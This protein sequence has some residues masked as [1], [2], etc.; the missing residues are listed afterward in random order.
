MNSFS[1]FRAY[2]ALV[3]VALLS[4]ALPACNDEATDHRPGSGIE[5]CVTEVMGPDRIEVYRC[6]RWARNGDDTWSCDCDG[7]VIAHV[8]AQQSCE[9]AVTAHC[10][11]PAHRISCD[12]EQLGECQVRDGEQRCRCLGGEAR[13][14][15]PEATCSPALFE[16]CEGEFGG[17][18]FSCSDALRGSCAWNE[19]QARFQCDCLGEFVGGDPDEGE[20]ELTLEC[21]LALVLTC[22][23]RICYSHNGRCGRPGDD[24][25]DDWFCEC[26]DGTTSM[27]TSAELSDPDDCE[28]APHIACP[29]STDGEPDSACFYTHEDRTRS[30]C[31]I[32]NHAYRCECLSDGSIGVR[33]GTLESQ[34]PCELLMYDVCN[35]ERD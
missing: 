3:L 6:E 7:D 11:I 20:A 15:D 25:D 9:A 22:D 14:V 23:S 2:A 30:S 19:E 18:E 33:A 17:A 5:S 24:N 32:W 10:E 35:I 29:D 26:D 28:D 34:W 1:R 16:N 4:P 13:D 27:V 21:G 31:E 12:G 8:P